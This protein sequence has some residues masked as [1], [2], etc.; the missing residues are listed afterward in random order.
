M[1]CSTKPILYFVLILAYCSLFP[2]LAFSEDFKE[3]VVF[4]DQSG[5][6]N[7]HDSKLASKDWM[8]AFLKTLKKPYRIILIGFDERIR[9]LLDFVISEEFE[10]DLIDREIKSLEVKGRSTDLER[11]FKYLVEKQNIEDV[12]FAL[13]ISDGVPEVFDKKLGFLSQRVREDGRYKDL[14]SQYYFMKKSEE[15]PEKIYDKV[16]AAFHNRNISL[17]EAALPKIR[18]ILG[19]RLIIWDISGHSEYLKRWSEIAGAQY[20]P[21]AIDEGSS[22]IQD[23]IKAA[24]SIHQEESEPIKESPASTHEP[25]V[26]DAAS[27]K[28]SLN[29][30]SDTGEIVKETQEF[31]VNTWVIY[32]ILGIILAVVMRVWLR[33]RTFFKEKKT[34]MTNLS[35]ET[36]QGYS[37]NATTEISKETRKARDKKADRKLQMPL[38]LANTAKSAAADYLSRKVKGVLEE[39]GDIKNKLLKKNISIVSDKK[40]EV[41]VEVPEGALEVYWVNEDGNETKADALDISVHGVRFK[42]VNFKTNSIKAIKC[43]N[44]QLSLNVTQSRFLRKTDSEVIVILEQFENNTKDWMKWIELLTRVDKI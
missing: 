17:I 21:I 10:I 32:S 14:L 30:K 37:A 16:G 33:K 44:L 26:K 34:N 38:D 40:F 24:S 18:G 15:S 43:P 23:L 11:P 29:E 5:S 12:E 13:I 39:A 19:N 35:E 3:I 25:L 1:L 36:L 7:E 20:I 22:P 2:P 27:E 42:N 8:L 4:F 41:R 31:R 28:P 6:T 9:T